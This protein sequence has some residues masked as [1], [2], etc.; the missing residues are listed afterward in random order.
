MLR[1]ASSLDSARIDEFGAAIEFNTIDGLTFDVDGLAI[2]AFLPLAEIRDRIDQLS[3]DEVWQLLREAAEKDES[4]VRVTS[5]RMAD[6]DEPFVF[7]SHGL[8]S[9]AVTRPSVWK[10]LLWPVR[11]H[12]GPGSSDTQAVPVVGSATPPPVRT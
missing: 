2:T 7:A 4:E 10:C 6:S 3:D 9:F 1:Y 8:K 12:T 5:G 11:N